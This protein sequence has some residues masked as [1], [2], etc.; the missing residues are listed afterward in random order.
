V[1]EKRFLSIEDLEHLPPP[2]WRI[3]GIFECD[4]AVLVAGP[5]ASLKT[6]VALSWVLSIATGVKWCDRDVKQGKVLYLLGEGKTGLL[7]RIQAWCAY[8][9]HDVVAL[10]NN[11]RVSFVVPQLANAIDLKILLQDLENENFSPDIIVIDTF[12]RSFV[13][14]EENS[15]KELGLWIESIG[16]LRHLGYTIICLHHTRKNT[17]Q[18]LMERGNTAFKGGID[19]EFI[20][21]RHH[22]QPKK[23]ILTCKK[24]KEHIEPPP[25]WL[26]HLTIHANGDKEGS[27]VIV[28]SQAPTKA[29]QA[30][31]HEQ[32][33]YEESILTELLENKT[34]KSDRARA[35]EFAN[36]AGLT[37]IA[38]QS[39]IKRK[40]KRNT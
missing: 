33:A 12:A 30:A 7:R 35:R 6:F 8:H 5:A 36:K 16:K 27:L 34:F 29:D 2:Q 10:R 14:K 22:N 40:R 13:G 17:E 26:E 39:R 18:G 31:E 21:Q 24:Q 32:L 9:N 25:I 3:H 28:P 4:S 23:I 1:S 15:A 19:T 11:F 20:L 37:E 38:A